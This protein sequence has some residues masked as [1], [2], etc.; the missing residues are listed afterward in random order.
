MCPY[1]ALTTFQNT[2][3]QLDI[4]QIVRNCMIDEIRWPYAQVVTRS[5]K[6]RNLVDILRRKRRGWEFPIPL[7][8]LFCIDCEE[9][10]RTL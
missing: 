7:P 1:I 6:I 9:K 10:E 3:E 2:S 5:L 8:F 4:F